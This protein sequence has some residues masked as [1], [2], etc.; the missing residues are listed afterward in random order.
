M[1]RVSTR[2][3]TLLDKCVV[4]RERGREKQTD[5]EIIYIDILKERAR[6]TNRLLE[7]DR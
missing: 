6:G 7:M 5:R 2:F 4:N 3:S 1:L